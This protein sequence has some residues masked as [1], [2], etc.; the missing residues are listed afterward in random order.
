MSV[1]QILVELVANVTALLGSTNVCAK[2]ITREQI[3]NN[4]LQ[5]QVREDMA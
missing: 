4:G 3:V 1:L 5:I 2:V